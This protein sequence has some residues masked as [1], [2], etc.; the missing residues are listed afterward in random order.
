MESRECIEQPSDGNDG[1]G[2]LCITGNG[3][4]FGVCEPIE[5][6]INETPEN[7]NC[8]A[9]TDPGCFDWESEARWAIYIFVKWSF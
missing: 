2:R 1:A 4:D 8:T 7:R 6:L 5:G 9:P 3:I